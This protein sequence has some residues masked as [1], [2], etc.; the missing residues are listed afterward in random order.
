MYAFIFWTSY[1]EMGKSEQT[2]NLTLSPLL[3]TFDN[4]A[5][6]VLGWQPQNGLENKNTVQ[7]YCKLKM[8]EDDV[9]SRVKC[10]HLPEWESGRNEEL[11]N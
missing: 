8:I 5:A 7:S 3:L 4:S 9:I 10:V 1:W 2:S 6:S 11:G